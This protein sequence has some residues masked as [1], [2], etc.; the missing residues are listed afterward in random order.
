MDVSALTDWT[1]RQVNGFVG[2]ET[3]AAY[4]S[5]CPK[6]GS[7][8]PARARIDIEGEGDLAGAIRTRCLELGASAEAEDRQVTRIKVRVMAVKGSTELACLTFRVSQGADDEPATGG[9]VGG[10]AAACIRELR[11][12]A[13]A[14]GETIK[15]QGAGAFAFGMEALKQNADLL[16][17]NAELTGALIIAENQNKSGFDSF[18][19]LLAPIM[20]QLPML[21]AGL[22]Q[23][24]SAPTEPPK[25]L[26]GP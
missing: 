22:V 11:Q 9:T 4:V 24:F 13:V 21:V 3:P 2:R 10:E 12:L 17:G 14:Q 23:K 8:Y 15:Q 16:K 19:E 26:P 25:A 6:E 1:V 5:L 20:P 7:A 18:K